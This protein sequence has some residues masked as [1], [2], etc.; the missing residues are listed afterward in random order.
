M[1]DQRCPDPVHSAD[2]IAVIG[3]AC[4][5][6]G[7]DGPEAF[8]DLL[9]NG[10]SAVRDVR[11]RW[12]GATGPAR[13]GAL[14]SSVDGFDPAFFG[15]GER[16]AALMDPRQRLLLEL[17]WEVLENG[18]V[19]AHSVEGSALGV[20]VGTT[21]DDYAHI[22]HRTPSALRSGHAMTGLHRNMIANRLSYFLRA[23]GPS[24]TVDTG[25]S[26][27]LVAVHLA[28]ESLRSG[29]SGT[30]LAAG[31]SL[32]LLRASSTISD[33]WGALSPDGRC[34]TFD[35]RANG[36]VRGEGGGAVLLKPLNRALADG[37]RVLGV[38]R[39]SAVA[40]GA[41][42][43]PTAPDPG[44]QTELLRAAHRRAGTE[45][46]VQYVELHGTG[47]PVGDPVEATA[48]GAALGDL[49]APL[50][51]GSVKTNIGHLEG[52][53]GI[54]GLIKVVLAVRY[55]TLPA[56]LNFTTPNPAIDLPGLGLSV[57]TETKPWPRP[58]LPLVAGVSSFGMGGANC[59]VVVAEPP[60]GEAEVAATTAPVLAWPV[61]ARSAE[62][63]T[64]AVARLRELDADPAD[65]AWS[66]A[67]TRAE[68]DHR[69]VLV[70]DREISGRGDGSTLGFAFAGQGAQRVGMGL[71]LREVH[72]AYAAAFDEVCELACL[73]LLGAV[74]DGTDLDRT[75][76]TQ[77]ALFAV[78]VALHRLLESWGLRPDVLVGHSVGEI[79]AAHVAGV[80]DLPDAVRLVT[81]RGALMAELPEGGAMARVRASARDVT[82]LLRDD[83][84]IAA[85]NGP[86]A[87]VIAGPA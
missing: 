85:V 52:A 60:G 32:A 40:T 35:E 87:V 51:V 47:T 58:D 22:V 49:A 48:V 10:R 53:A 75:R 72:P 24:I 65:V 6:P 80:L 2:D 78:E 11:D 23:T 41:G 15:I 8:W 61:S 34:H 14:L 71:R 5:F 39:G 19:P 84:V 86:D 73:D 76:T 79:A 50:P 38:I 46:Q 82:P 43:T 12:P 63:R 4:R 18:R 1:I 28:C 77:P 70:G 13:W 44:T 64:A 27:S 69:A 20:F 37:D 66:L 17:G 83:V 42:A 59:H 54:A 9:V 26:S 29:E 21:W 55:R 7:A 62:A 33:E 74:R 68:L 31:V 67:T 56:S 25:Q 57:V 30:A 36:Y 45:G 16:E 3:V 81:A